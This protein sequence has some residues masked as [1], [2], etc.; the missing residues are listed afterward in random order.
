MEVETAVKTKKVS[1]IGTSGVGKTTLIKMLT[2]NVIPT[3][4]QPTI[5]LDFQNI[6]FKDLQISMWELG[7]QEQFQF[8][9]DDFIKG[10]SLICVVSDS[11]EKNVLETKKIISKYNNKRNQM[12]AIANKQDNKNKTL[13]PKEI[14][15]SLG[16]E[17]IGMVAIEKS[18]RRILLN[19]LE[20]K[21]RSL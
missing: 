5:A 14:Q 16:I 6:N 12:I 13:S 10:S 17:T 7:G 18:N 21:M 4:H 11:T 19:L 9:W 3:E 2:N 20:E 1:F 15:K 8:M